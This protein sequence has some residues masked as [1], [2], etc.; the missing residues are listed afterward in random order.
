VADWTRT[1]PSSTYRGWQPL[2][3]PRRPAV[4]PYPPRGRHALPRGT[5]GDAQ[6]ALHGF[7]ARWL[8]RR[9]AAGGSA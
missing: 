9:L 7:S 5:R 3:T 6:A 8:G 2:I 4:G 1:E